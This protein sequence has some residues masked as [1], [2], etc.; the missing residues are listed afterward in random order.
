MADMGVRKP[1]LHNPYADSLETRISSATPLELV[2]ILYD[3]AIE[4]VRAARGHLA[5]GEIHLR[6]N[7]IT[8]TV[9]ILIELSRSLNMEAGGELS[10]RLAGLYDFMQRSL[11]DANFRQT[12]EQLA[13]TERL[14]V[15][16]REAWATLSHRTSPALPF[17]PIVSETLNTPAGR[18]WSA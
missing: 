3:G 1:M 12:D 13:T 6:S 9:N 17:V 4:A 7:A 8:K 18:S 5:S 10:K 2:T 15:S 16:L 14:L 11:L